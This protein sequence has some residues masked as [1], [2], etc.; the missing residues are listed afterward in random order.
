MCK[1]AEIASKLFTENYHNEKWFVK[2]DTYGVNQIIVY[3]RYTK[4]WYDDV[5]WGMIHRTHNHYADCYVT[6]RK[7]P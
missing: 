1:Q 4:K 7:V 6:W 5:L 3:Y 2:A